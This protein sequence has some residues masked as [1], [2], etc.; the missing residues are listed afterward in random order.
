MRRRLRHVPR[1][2]LGRLHVALVALI[3]VCHFVDRLRLLGGRF[4]SAGKLC[5]HWAA[6]ALRALGGLLGGLTDR[7]SDGGCV[8]RHLNG[9]RSQLNE[10][11]HRRNNTGCQLSGRLAELGRDL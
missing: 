1:H 5:G 2:D 4:F 3:V 6:A 8:L 11:R 10:L 9:V 7:L